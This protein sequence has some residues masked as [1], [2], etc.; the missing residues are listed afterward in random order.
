MIRFLKRILKEAYTHK[1][2]F[3]I[4]VVVMVVIM[5]ALFEDNGIITRIQLVTKKSELRE[6]VQRAEIENAR[7]K[8]YIKLL[9]SDRKTIEKVAREKYGMIK[10]GEKVYKIEPKV[11]E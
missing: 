8:E 9:E 7:L 11:E 4:L 5:Y 6:K 10:E 2:P 1:G 3:L